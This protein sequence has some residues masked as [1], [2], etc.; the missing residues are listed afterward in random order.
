MLSQTVCAKLRTWLTVVSFNSTTRRAQSSIIGYFGFSL[1]LRT[2]KF[3]TLLFGV[4]VH[5]AGCDKQNSLMCAGLCGKQ[6]S[7]LN[8]I[9]CCIVDCQSHST[10]CRSNCQI[11][12]DY[13]RDFCLPYLH[14]RPP[15]GGS[16]SEYC[17]NVWYRKTRIVWLP[18]G[19]KNWRC[20]YSFWQNTRLWRTDGQIDRWTDTAR[21]LCIQ[22]RGKNVASWMIFLINCIH[23]LSLF[24]SFFTI[25]YFFICVKICLPVAWWLPCDLGRLGPLRC[26]V[27]RTWR[28]T[29]Q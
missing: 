24:L 21:R 26:W 11:V 5:A 3:C 13:Y 25:N 15:L 23:I 28:V 18:D 6:M 29:L 1:P 17:H 8:G 10:S 16:L 12:V 4:V 22:S 19:E 27:V 20:V 14:S 7:T 2:I 9:N